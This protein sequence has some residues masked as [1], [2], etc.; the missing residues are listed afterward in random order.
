MDSY[1]VALGSAVW[2]GI[3]TSISP[4]P[5]ATNIAAIT[6]I[7]KRVDR[8]GMVLL[9]G[10]MYTLGRAV[11]YITLGVLLVASIL[12]IPNVALFLQQNM[13]KFLG[14][15]LILVGLLLLGIL[16]IRFPGG[17]VSDKLTGR[18][19]RWGI[20]G[21]GALGLLFALSFCP[22]SAALFFG[23]LIPLAV[24]H[25]SSV[26]MPT[27]YGIGTAL[28]V[29]VFAVLIALGARFVGSAFNKISVFEKW[30]RRLTAVAFI[31][32]GIYYSL[33]Y[34]VGLDI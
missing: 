4:C 2:L 27:V 26:M 7:G 23:S 17:G 33:I 12:S 34:L 28:P 5:L 16:N 32:V 11:A 24:D 13:N 25:R 1:L 9:S 30:A 20:W 8:P 21:A 19:E 6:Y 31:I 14:P 3:L 18:V 15:I 29:V 10:V 22:V